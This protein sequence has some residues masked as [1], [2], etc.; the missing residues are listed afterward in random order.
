MIRSTVRPAATVAK[1]LGKVASCSTVDSPAAR[2]CWG[3]A[4]PDRD[5]QAPGAPVRRAVG[6][7]DDLVGR[8]EGLRAASTTG[9][10]AAAL[11]LD[12]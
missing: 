4:R 12:C 2:S 9:S 11:T 1:M 3:A 5:G 6:G 7:A 10:A 8:G